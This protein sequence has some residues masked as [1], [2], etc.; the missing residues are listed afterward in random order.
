MP[1]IDIQ[2]FFRRLLTGLPLAGVAVATSMP[3]SERAHQFLV[4]ITLIWFQV[5]ILSEVFSPGK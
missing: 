3:I 2:K 4:M 1:K 5:F